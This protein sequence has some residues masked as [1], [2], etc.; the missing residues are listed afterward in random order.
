MHYNKE[1]LN[2]DSPTAKDIGFTSD[3][4]NSGIIW[5]RLP[6]GF[7]ISYLDPKTPEGLKQ[8]LDKILSKGFLIRYTTPCLNQQYIKDMLTR[9]GYVATKDQAG[10]VF[11]ENFIVSSEGKVQR[12]KPI[13]SSQTLL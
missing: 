4:F 2:K 9:Y 1:I 7:Y 10:S 5:K 6:Q 13:E 12:L 11:Y 3:A 8:M